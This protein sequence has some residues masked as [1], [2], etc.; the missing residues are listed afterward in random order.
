M[1]VDLCHV[2]IDPKV[3]TLYFLLN[4]LADAPQKQ[5]TLRG[6]AALAVVGSHLAIAEFSC[7]FYNVGALW[8]YDPRAMRMRKMDDERHGLFQGDG[9]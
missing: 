8:D 3:G 6:P 4:D 1:S 7:A 5:I 2:D 9:S